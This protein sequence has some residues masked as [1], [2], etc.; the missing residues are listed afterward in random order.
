MIID[1]PNAN[2]NGLTDITPY[3]TTYKTTPDASAPSI[4]FDHDSKVWAD[5]IS[6]LQ[7]YRYD[8]VVTIEHEN[9]LMSVNEGFAKTIQTLRPGVM[10]KESVLGMWWVR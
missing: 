2:R 1:Q 6:T 4:E 5:I 9:E 8:Y 3:S 10:V 7:L